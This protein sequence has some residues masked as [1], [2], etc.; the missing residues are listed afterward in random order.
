ME[1]LQSCT[2]PSRWYDNTK[3]S[4]ELVV[5]NW[6]VTANT[7]S[8]TIR[9]SFRFGFQSISLSITWQLVFNT[10]CLLVACVVS[11]Q[12]MK[13]STETVYRYAWWVGK[14]GSTEIHTNKTT[15]FAAIIWQKINMIYHF[16]TPGQLEYSLIDEMAKYN[17]NAFRNYVAFLAG[18]M[19]PGTRR[20]HR[21]SELTSSYHEAF[22]P[23]GHYHN[24]IVLFY[25]DSPITG[26]HLMEATDRAIK[27]FMCIYSNPCFTHPHHGILTYQ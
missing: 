5:C 15:P 6:R 16:Y 19:A 13:Q 26:S 1:L 14:H 25:H 2:K 10:L 9:F 11:R 17:W 23:W 22:L 20:P 24:N 7:L 3:K 21:D 4:H 27:G 12:I 18:E 8:E